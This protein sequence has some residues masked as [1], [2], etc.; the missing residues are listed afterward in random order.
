[1][2]E[3]FFNENPQT[4]SY[5]SIIPD[6]LAVKNFKGEL[7]YL[8]AKEKQNLLDESVRKNIFSIKARLLK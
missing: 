5:E 4:G 2:D 3:D 7:D 1:M 8:V 6:Y